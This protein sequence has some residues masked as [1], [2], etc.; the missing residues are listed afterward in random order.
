[1]FSYSENAAAANSAVPAAAPAAKIFIQALNGDG[2]ASLRDCASASFG[3]K[4]TAKK[5]KGS[6]Q[7][8]RTT[9][10]SG[11]GGCK[12]LAAAATTTATAPQGGAKAHQ[13]KKSKKKEEADGKNY[14]QSRQFNN[15]LFFNVMNIP[16]HA[17][18][19]RDRWCSS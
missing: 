6:T 15:F 19:N 9:A 18:R 4:Q 13:K 14:K 8:A 16:L 7:S 5:A 2:G 3:D 1:V 12:D 11:G 17:R 10:A